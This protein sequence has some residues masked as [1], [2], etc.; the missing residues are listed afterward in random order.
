M[1]SQSHPP[2]TRTQHDEAAGSARVMTWDP[3]VRLF[4]WTVVAGCLFN[5][6]LDDGKLAHRWVGYTVAAVLAIRIYKHESHLPH[7]HHQIQ[8]HPL[9]A[10]PGFDRSG[11]YRGEIGLAKPTVA[12]IRGLHGMEHIATG[13]RYPCKRS[14]D[15]L[16]NVH[17][18]HGNPK[19]R[20]ASM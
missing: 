12:R 20:A 3:V 1:T 7:G 18:A 17:C 8:S 11:S 16:V 4:H 2:F 14:A 19:A 5:F 13:H 9:M 10:L 15:N 6:V